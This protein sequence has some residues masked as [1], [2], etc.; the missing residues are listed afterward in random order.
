MK[1]ETLPVIKGENNLPN[2]DEAYANF[3]WE[4]VNK[5]FTWNETGRVNMAYEAIDKHA[6]SDRKNKVALY[7]QDGSRKEKYTF[8]EMK[9]FSNKAGNVLKNY[10]DV[11][12]GDRVF[13]FMP[14]SPELYFA[15]LGAVKL[16][17][18]VGPLFEAF[19]EGAVRD[20]LED[21]EAK[22]LI[23]TP[24]LLER[25]PL[26]DLPALKTVFLVGD[27]VEEGGK[28]VAFNPLFEQASKELH[29]EWLGREDGLIL[30][31]TSGSTGKPKGVLH[32][33]NAMV[34]HYQT[35]KWV[36]DLK[37]DDVYWCTADPGWVTGTAYG[38]FAPWLVGASN[39]ILGGR[40]SP[41][42]WYEALQDY[43]VTVWYSAPTA[44]RMLMGAGQDAIKKYDLSQ[45][46]H[47]LSVGEPLNPEVIRWG[48]NAFGLRIHDT[49]WMTET[50]G[51]VIC[52][53]PCME[54][55]PGSMGKPIP[56][57]KAA[58]VD[59][60]GNEVPPYTMG[61][62]AIAKG[63]PSMMRGIWNNQQKYES[64]F[65]PGD[66]Y[67]SGDSAYMDE[68]GYFWFQGRIDDVIMTS[69]ERVGPFEVESKLI[70]H[71]AVAEAGVIGIPD[72][73][74]GEIIK[75]FIALRAGYE[76]SDEL[77]EEIRQF[78][79]KG[80]AAHAAP[81]QIEFRDK[82]PK[83]RSGK[84]MRRVLKAWELNLPTG[85]LSTMED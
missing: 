61:N 54:I 66:W 78:V 49:W 45:V 41:E 2:Y 46:R 37:E 36:L 28:T 64:Y 76:P 20:R 31:Y 21:S 80:L 39:V 34:Q 14:R 48:M 77:K 84:I 44:F 62:L 69:G 24:E 85:D 33:Q 82:L 51:Q 60:E 17:A 50:G 27:N 56:G 52:N 53:Y 65:M 75:A 18:I 35:A 16:G 4:E 25:V 6:K 3:N 59:N 10:G 40:F 81:R 15:L 42:A 12:K 7:Y 72:P 67:V 58:I 13:I 71:A 73:V 43:G 38:I 68:D 23:T 83:T 30:H 29:I 11:E 57:V 79:K 70:E 9:D 1:V 63:W 32:A 8:K 55:R 26:N 19:M 5:N 47:V 22:V 74:R